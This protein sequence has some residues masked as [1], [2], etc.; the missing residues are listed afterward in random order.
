MRD[1]VRTI[2]FSELSKSVRSVLEL[3]DLDVIDIEQEDSNLKATLRLHL[4]TE[5]AVFTT[6]EEVYGAIKYKACPRCVARSAGKYTH[7]VQIRFTKKSPPPR[8]VEELKD[9]L[10]RLL[11][12]SSVVDVKYSESGLDLELDDATIAKRVVQ[13]ITREYSA[14]LITTF[15]ATRFNHRKGAWQGVVTYSLRIPVLEKGELVI[16]RK[17]LYVV[18]DV[19]RNRVVLYN[20]SSSTREE[21]SLSAYWIGELKCPSRVEVERYV[22]KSVENG[23]IIAVSESTKSEL[24]I[25]RKHNTPQLGVGSTVFLIKADNIETIVIGEVNLSR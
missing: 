7:L 4:R 17:S 24:I 10:Q 14:K 8:I 11:P 18:E 3:V 23:R 22:V 21:A 13:A 12:Q 19:K 1:V 15:K 6:V 5:T 25:R 16:Y 9:L 2:G 20:L